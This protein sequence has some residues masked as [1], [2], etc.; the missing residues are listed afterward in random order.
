MRHTQ[1]LRGFT[2]VELLVVIGI[3]VLLMG[4]A[5]PAIHRVREAANRL[6]CGNHLRQIGMALHLYHDDYQRLPPSRLSDRRATWAVLILP[7][8][9]QQNLFQSW[10]LS[11][12]Y[13]EQTAA[14]RQGRVPVYFCP[15]RRTASSDPLVSL[16]GDVSSNGVF[17]D[18]HYPGALG[19]YAACMGTT[20]MDFD[21]PGC[22]GMSPNGAFEYPR[23][24]RFADIIDGLSNTLMVGEKHVPLGRFGYGWLDCSLYNGDYETCSCR[25]AGKYPTSPI[26]FGLARSLT[27]RW[28]LFGSYHPGLCQFVFCDGHVRALPVGIDL[29][30]LTRLS[31]RYDGGVV[32]DF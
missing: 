26:G 1:R 32:D 24:V 28:P 7:Y 22:V 2:L 3:I 29:E 11:R 13:Y 16:T 8:L 18:T 9:E 12:S 19:D 6:Q 17:G 31:H 25:P 5:L 20:G 10:N 14:A 27:E 4:L 23:G 30:T 21:G 15:T